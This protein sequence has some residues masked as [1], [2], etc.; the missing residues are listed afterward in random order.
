MVLLSDTDRAYEPIERLDPGLSIDSWR[1]ELH[2][3]RLGQVGLE[4]TAGLGPD[5]KGQI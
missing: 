5:E 2:Q 3:D 4:A 1:R